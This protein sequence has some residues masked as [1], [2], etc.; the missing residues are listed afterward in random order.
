MTSLHP[1][2]PFIYPNH[3]H[4]RKHGPSGYKGYESYR[5]WLRDEFDFSCVYTLF[6]ETWVGKH[7]FEI[8]HVIPQTLD[9]EAEC[10]Y[11]NLVYAYHFVNRLKSAKLIPHP[12]SLVLGNCLEV[13]DLGEISAR[14]DAG[15]ALMK[16]LKLDHPELTE[17]RYTWIRGLTCAQ[18]SDPELYNWYMRMPNGLVD[19]ARRNPPRNSKPEGVSTSLYARLHNTSN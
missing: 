4:E 13:N 18:E 3:P 10:D 11:E 5:E 7:N 9:G 8:E 19:L 2:N 6:R 1:M 12:C 15:V 17:Q 14:S 16:D